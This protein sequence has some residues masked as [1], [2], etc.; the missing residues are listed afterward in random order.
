MGE[1]TL[2]SVCQL[3]PRPGGGEH[4]FRMDSTLI[5]GQDGVPPSQ[6]RM[7]VPPCQQ[8]GVTPLQV[9][10]QD[11]GGTPIW[12]SIAC[13]YY[14][15]FDQF[16]PKIVWKWRNFGRRWARPSHPPPSIRQ[17]SFA[18][19]SKAETQR[20]SGSRS[21]GQDQR[22][23]DFKGSG[24][25]WGQIIWVPLRQNLGHHPRNPLL[26]SPK[27]GQRKSLGSHSTKT[28][29]RYQLAPPPPRPP[30]TTVLLL[31]SVPTDFHVVMI[32]LIK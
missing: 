20:S 3:T 27:S 32:K 19:G 31:F 2:I 5:Q 16:F 6:I 4:Q 8:N 12:N 7:G 18:G 30:C 22:R 9:L 24:H 17:C 23:H 10:G 14:I 11:E 1:G 13:T 28:W 15:L 26:Q 29:I 21:P 25:H